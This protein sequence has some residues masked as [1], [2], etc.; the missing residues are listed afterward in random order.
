M[1]VKENDGKSSASS[2][3]STTFFLEASSEFSA[4]DVDLKNTLID[5]QGIM[6]NKCLYT[7]FFCVLCSSL[8][9]SYT[10]FFCLGKND[11]LLKEI[12]EIKQQINVISQ[13]KECIEKNTD[14]IYHAAMAELAIKDKEFIELRTELQN[15]SSELQK[16]SSFKTDS[17]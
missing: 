12:E 2:D 1:C 13:E 5:L 4:V 16:S 14:A 11:A 10:V 17:H 8:I 15:C 9:M 7:V 6:S 3:D